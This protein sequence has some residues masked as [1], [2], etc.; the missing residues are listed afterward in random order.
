MDNVYLKYGLKISDLMREVKKLGLE[1][2]PDVKA[3]SEQI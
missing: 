3:L 2:D 1:N